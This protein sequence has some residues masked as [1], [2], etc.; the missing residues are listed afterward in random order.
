MVF[1]PVVLVITSLVPWG[2][3]ARRR[4]LRQRGM[5]EADLQAR[6]RWWWRWFLAHCAAGLLLV[7][8]AA[9]AAVALD[10]EPR[11]D[12]RYAWRGWYVEGALAWFVVSYALMGLTQGFRLV[13]KGVL[14]LRRRAVA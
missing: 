5:T 10:T 4:R 6:G 11:P 13:R 3:A 7:L 1:L 8:A 12:E 2:V 14:R 9:G